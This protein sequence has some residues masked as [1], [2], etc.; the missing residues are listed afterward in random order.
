MNDTAPPTPPPP[1]PDDSAS[2]SSLFQRTLRKLMFVDLPIKRKFLLFA[3][4]ALFWFAS[5]AVVAV[6]ALSAIHFKYHQVSE[7]SVPYIQTTRT[8]LES[9]Q[10][11]ERDL[12]RMLDAESM[13]NLPNADSAR[14]RIKTIRA[15]V[16]DLSLRRSDS[17]YAGTIIETVLRT[18]ATSN[19][20]NVQYLQRMLSVTEQLDRSFDEFLLQKRQSLQS[21]DGNGAA[22]QASFETIHGLVHEATAVT[23]AHAEHL[24]DEYQGTNLQIYQI[25]RNSVHAMIVVLV[26][27]TFLLILFVRWLIVAFQ[28]PIE[29]IIDQIDALSMGD[30]DHAKKVSVK[31]QDEI[32]TLSQKFNS[33]MDS[34]YGMTIYKKVIEEDASLDEVYHRLGEVFRNELGIE[35]FTIFEVD[36]QQKEMRVGY[37]PLVGDS[38]LQC[39][40]DVLVD[41]T[42]CRAVKTGHNVSSFEYAGIC[43][44]F[45]G[46]GD[47]GHICIPM[48]LGGKTGGVVQLRFPAEKSDGALPSE[49]A[50]QLFR[51]ETYINQS[52]SVIEAK[53]LMQTLRDSALIDPLTGLYNRRFLQEHTNQ[54]ISGVVRRKKQVGLLICDLDY[55]K[56]VNDTHGH[57]VGDQLL[58]E[59]STILK[60]AVREADVVIRFGG[61]EFL[62]LLMDVEPGDAMAVAEK[63]RERIEQMKFSV[64]GTTLQKTISIGVSEYPSDADGFWQAI[65]FAD[66]ALYQ[67]KESGRNQ[68]V[69]FSE[70]MW[71]HGDF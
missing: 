19:P 54:L 63:I 22:L 21:A 7:Q 36:S 24:T 53:R 49:R 33:L 69:R 39:D 29:S 59:T 38:T 46:E 40:E 45:T 16:A 6:T 5:M 41:C 20:E 31:A 50:R 27:A 48:M 61:E 4:G 68:A 60:N 9:L 58:Q 62:V 71:Q 23:S 34:V 66:V 15:D 26:I 25:I 30:I 35:A 52:L 14:D 56:Q 8:V 13:A 55:F 67:A 47:N 18:L 42:L 57:D 65:K 10:D 17:T 1:A 2:S 3:G 44:R 37:P 43:R 12:H 51:A 32:G 11:I 64:S 70:E 28:Q